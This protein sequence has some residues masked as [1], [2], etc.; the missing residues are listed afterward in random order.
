[1]ENKVKILIAEN[2]EF[3]QNCV[4]EFSSYGYNALLS[5]KDGAQVLTKM[6]YEKPDVII[7]DAFMLH[8]DALGV[9]KQIREMKDGK[10][11]MLIV[12]SSVDNMRFESEILNSG[13][14]YYF[15][16]PVD[17]NIIAQRITQLAGWKNTCT[18]QGLSVFER[19]NHS[20]NKQ[21]RDDG[22]CNEASLPYGCQDIQNNII[23]S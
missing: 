19:S 7:M 5:D 6:K 8:V 22:L 3:G 4:R 9:I 2:N 13:A 1:M 18:H 15:L 23:E 14:D 16:K 10:K 20:F 17:A 12:L 21:Y 11:P